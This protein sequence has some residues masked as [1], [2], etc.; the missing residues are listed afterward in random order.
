MFLAQIWMM[1]LASPMAQTPTT[2][3][4]A[5]VQR[6]V[7]AYNAFDIEAFLAAHS[8]TAEVRFD[9]GGQVLK[10]RAALRSFYEPGF[11]RRDTTVRI[12]HRTIL[13]NTIVDE[14]HVTV[15][16]KEVCCAVLIF[17]VTDGKI[18]SVEVFL[19]PLLLQAFRS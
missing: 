14:E 11:R 2:S 15:R 4:E 9:A 17:K 16:G 1:A 5:V 8:E 3:A 6:Q 10:G 7:D 13:G 18:G 12:G 19:S